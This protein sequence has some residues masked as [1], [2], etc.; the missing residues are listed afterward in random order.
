MQIRPVD[1]RRNQWEVGDPVF[2]VHFWSRQESLGDRTGARPTPAGLVVDENEITGADAER[3]LEWARANAPRG[4]GF[5]LYLAIA[6]TTD[7][8]GVV[9]LSG[10]LPR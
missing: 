10:N 8:Q 2:Q 7:G 3:V 5:V 9:R 1:S 6:D 4:G